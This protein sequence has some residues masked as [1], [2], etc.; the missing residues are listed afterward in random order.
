[1]TP[2]ENAKAAETRLSTLWIDENGVLYSA[3]KKNV[4]FTVENI[5]EYYDSVGK[6]TEGNNIYLCSDISEI[7]VP[8]KQSRD[9]IA[10][11]A[12]DYPF[13]AAAVITKSKLS[14]A[15]GNIMLIWYKFPF[16]VK[17]FTDEDMAQDWL[18]QYQ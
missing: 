5:T 2:P 7:A 13:K 17:L 14:E 9:L 3:A 1:M 10:N 4:P 6:I 12:L 18:K 16:P 11:K 15:I 8:D